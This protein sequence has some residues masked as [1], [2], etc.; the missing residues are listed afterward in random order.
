MRIRSALGHQSSTVHHQSDL[1]LSLAN[2]SRC[3]VALGDLFEARSYAEKA[4][5]LHQ[6]VQRDAPGQFEAELVSS[7]NALFAVE[8]HEEKWSTSVEMAQEIVRI[9][10]HLARRIPREIAPGLAD[11]FYHLTSCLSKLDQHDEALDAIKRTVF[12]PE[13]LVYKWPQVDVFKQRLDT[14]FQRIIM[15]ACSPNC[16]V[17]SLIS[18]I[19][20]R[21]LLSFNVQI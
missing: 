6:E 9:Q 11:A 3:H 7:L 13:N 17:F 8:F 15:Q 21:C 10:E 5:R 1:V 14:S 4:V 12:I 19:T 16:Q 20:R 18:D 2:V